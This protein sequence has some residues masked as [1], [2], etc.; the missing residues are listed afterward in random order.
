MTIASSDRTDAALAALRA[1]VRDATANVEAAVLRPADE[2]VLDRADRARIALRVAVVNEHQG[3][4]EEVADLLD[5]VAGTGAA[6]V[7]RSVERWSELPEPTQALL[8]HCEHVALDPAD[9]VADDIASLLAQGLTAAQVVAASQVVGYASY[10]VRLLRGLE[11]LAAG[12]ESAPVEPV[13]TIEAGA[14][15]DGGAL[16]SPAEAFPVLRWIPRVE[17]VADPAGSDEKNPANLALRH[18]PDVLE[19]QTALYN[20]VLMSPG[21]LSRADR[22]LVALA[23]SLVTGCR[24][25]AARHGRRHAQLAQD[26][27]TSVALAEAGPAAVADSRHRAIIDAAGALATTP[28]ALTAGHLARLAAVGLGADEV[29]D[30]LAVA[31]LFSWTNRLTATLGNT[32][33]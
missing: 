2:A 22:E 18:D 16:P 12:G 21:H 19:R 17:P 33:R 23:T 11:L 10:R 3:Y 6:G 9:V 25:A 32:A 28:A 30:L 20:A 26:R 24:Y 1:D 29:R 13:T 4:A 7:V 15:A 27:I 8:A 14:T 31:A 5:S